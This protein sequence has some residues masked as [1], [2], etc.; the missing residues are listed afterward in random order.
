MSEKLTLNKLSKDRI[1]GF[2]KTHILQVCVLC[3]C[4]LLV[5]FCHCN[6]FLYKTTVAKVTSVKTTD[7]K[8]DNDIF[9]V[10][11]KTYTQ[12]MKATIKNG[13]DKGQTV[14]ITNN[15]LKSQ[16][17]N[18]KYKK[19][20][21]LLISKSDKG[22]IKILGQKMDGTLADAFFVMVVILLFVGRKKA[23]RTL[24]S[25]ALNVF[26]TISVIFIYSKGVNLLLLTVIATIIFLLLTLFLIDGRNIKSYICMFSTMIGVTLS[27]VIVFLTLTLTHSNG[28]FFEQMELVTSHV[29][30]IFYV[31]IIIGNLGGIMDITVSM[32]SSIGELIAKNP[33][34]PDKD[35]YKS[36][37]V[38]G[39]DIMGTMTSNILF[40]Y[41]AGSFPMILLLIANGYNFFYIY[42]NNLNIEVVRAL[43]G[44]IGMVITIPVA[45]FISMKV[46][47]KYQKRGAAK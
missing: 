41:I 5:V 13:K 30:E 39:S 47:K 15:Y 18:P 14:I 23:G 11:G 9:N 3:V 17:I 43:A 38:I 33:D 20:N 19:G 16:A 8:E 37:K 2:L 27:C 6:S 29:K 36:S 46:Y 35:I 24:L 40:A 21:M 28:V 31:Q 10:T 12:E 22:N 26:V 45:T 34:T 7:V 25:L 4:A 1:M 32:A 42:Q 44:C